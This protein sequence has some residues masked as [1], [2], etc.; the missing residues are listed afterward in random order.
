MAQEE[1]VLGVDVGGTKVAVAALH[2]VDVIARA[3]RPTVLSSSFE[4]G[5]APTFAPSRSPK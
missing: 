1:L 2:G 4:P 3:E 5:L